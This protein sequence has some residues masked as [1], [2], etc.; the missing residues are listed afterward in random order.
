MNYAMEMR[1]RKSYDSHVHA[2]IEITNNECFL[3]KTFGAA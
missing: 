3:Q 2:L 1:K